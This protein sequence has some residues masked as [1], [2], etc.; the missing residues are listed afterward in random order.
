MAC[1]VACGG[2]APRSTPDQ[3]PAL[4]ALVD[5]LLP[6]LEQLSALA[7]RDT[8]QVATR[9]PAQVRAFVETRLDEEFPPD[10]MEGVRAAYGLLRLIPDTLD[11]RAMLLELYTEQIVGY[12]DPET[13]ALYVVE[14]VDRNAV[15]PVLVHELVH[16]LQDQHTN[17]DSLIARARGNDRQL[18]AQA[19][20]EGHATLVMFMF[21]AAEQTGRALSARDLPDPAEQL[22]PGLEAANAQFPVFQRAPRAVREALLFPYIAG[23]SFVRRLWM[24]ADTPAAAPFDQL[25]PQSTEQVIHTEERF[26]FARDEPTELRFEN[27]PEGWSVV[28]ENT[29]GELETT[30]FLEEH[31][32]IGQATAMGWDGD[33]Y[34]VLNAPG[35]GRIMDWVIVFDDVA[36]ARSFAGHTQRALQRRKFN[37]QESTQEDRH[38]VRVRLSDNAAALELLPPVP[39]FC[40]DAAGSRQSCL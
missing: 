25:L 22:R 17:L 16:A 30:L 33:R 6:R 11:L 8:V 14:G 24:R 38:F 15:R 2:D 36:A 18:A 4:R 20:I 19:A 1:I 7:L 29:L 39:F 35:G 3:D 37:V 21:V 13:R 32:G 27:A 23:A 28:Y 10:E 34:R 5:S 40:T 12:Y 31:L 9:S 26:L